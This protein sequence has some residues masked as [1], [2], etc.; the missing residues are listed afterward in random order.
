MSN[1]KES[2]EKAMKLDGAVATALVDYESGLTLGT[3]GGGN[4]FDIEVAASGNTQVV[5]A[6]M[7][8]MHQLGIAG[9][10][11]DI[12]IT[13]EDQYHLIRPLSSNGSLFLYLAIDRTRGNLGLARH[14]L[15]AIENEV[16]V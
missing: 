9:S 16:I 14:Q 10:I 12:L 7:I 15:K 5:R 1:I 11:E 4:N 8:V 2:L 6:K 3:A 13:L